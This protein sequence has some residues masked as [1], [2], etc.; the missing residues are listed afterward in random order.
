MHR[1]NLCGLIIGH[2]RGQCIQPIAITTTVIVIAAAT[3][4]QH[5]LLC[6][7]HIR[8]KTSSLL[9][10]RARLRPREVRELALLIAHV[11]A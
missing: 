11:W 6:V 8:I 10:R 4:T 9:L 5:P 1:N 7:T 2:C 3:N